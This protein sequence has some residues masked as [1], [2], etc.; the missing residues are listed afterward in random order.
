MAD[1]RPDLTPEQAREVRRLLADARHTEPVPTDVAARLE[2][3]LAD[4]ADQQAA[5]APGVDDPDTT[6]PGTVTELASRRR[7][8]AATLLV[9]AAA[10][11]A[12]GVG[13]GQVVG[14][15]GQGQSDSSAGAPAAGDAPEST[16]A[17]SDKAGSDKAGSADGKGDSF[18][19]PQGS[20]EDSVSPEV[21]A[22]PDPVRVRS[23]HFS[24]DVRRVRREARGVPT[25]DYGNLRGDRD[26]RDCELMAWGRGTQV[27]VRYD[28]SPAVVVLRSPTGD[29]QVADLFRCGSED[30]LRST[31][32]PAR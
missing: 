18:N 25:A 6:A 13:L 31:T 27:L 12:V 5:H 32:L 10:V 8:R 2:R 24:A 30:P 3:V 21:A 29:T 15:A 23:D 20:G 14:K 1:E 19:G 28:G 17:G 11:V 4:L 7:R 16:R 26:V 22:L 9:A